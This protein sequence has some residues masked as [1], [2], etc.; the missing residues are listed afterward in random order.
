MQ[1]NHALHPVNVPKVS[2]SKMEF[3]ERRGERIRM[4]QYYHNVNADITKIRP[5]SGD[6]YTG[7]LG[8]FKAR[9]REVESRI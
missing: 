1:T 6:L 9:E 7:L 5:Q 8:Q 2:S 3:M 4:E